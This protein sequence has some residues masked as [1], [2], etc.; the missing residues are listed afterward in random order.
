M[1]NPDLHVPI[2]APTD[3]CESFQERDRRDDL[4]VLSIVVFL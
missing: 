4:A 2:E 1:E 3:H